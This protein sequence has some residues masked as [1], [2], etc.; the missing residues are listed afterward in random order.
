M[1]TFLN[2]VLL[3]VGLSLSTLAYAE[4]KFPTDKPVHGAKWPHC[5]HDQPATLS[6]WVDPSH[7]PQI[8]FP[9]PS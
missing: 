1:R 4:Q 7:L 6:D 5:V 3:I 2:S 9:T 8:G